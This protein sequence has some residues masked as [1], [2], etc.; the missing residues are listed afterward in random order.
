[1][2]FVLFPSFPS[3]K[4]HC[5]NDRN[6]DMSISL[7]L[8]AIL[9][10]TIDFETIKE[11]MLIISW[12]KYEFIKIWYLLASTSLKVQTKY[13]SLTKVASYKNIPTRNLNKGEGEVRWWLSSIYKWDLSKLFKYSIDLVENV[14]THFHDLLKDLQICPGDLSVLDRMIYLPVCLSFCSSSLSELKVDQL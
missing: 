12:W 2:T 6:T 7:H 13:L 8:T 14:A 9:Q 1:M 5:I 3:L 10:N 11:Y 4:V